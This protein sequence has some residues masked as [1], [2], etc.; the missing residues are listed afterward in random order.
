MLTLE[1]YEF[2][3]F[4]F[5]GNY[6]IEGCWLVILCFFIRY[7]YQIILNF[8]PFGLGLFEFFYIFMRLNYLNI[9]TK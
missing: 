3:L 9:F 1:V 4:G 8:F 5:I 7:N 6:I 2:F